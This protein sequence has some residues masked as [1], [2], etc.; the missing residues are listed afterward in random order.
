MFLS[1]PIDMRALL[2]LYLGSSITYGAFPAIEPLANGI[3]VTQ[4]K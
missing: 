4:A 1:H 2:D 3:L